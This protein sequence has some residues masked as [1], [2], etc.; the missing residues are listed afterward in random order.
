MATEKIEIALKKQL[1]ERID[2][3]AKMSGKSRN[4]FINDF[5]ESYLDKL[6]EDLALEK[7]AIK[8]YMAGK[9]EEKQLSL[10]VGKE[11]TE[12]AKISK[13]IG[14]KGEDLLKAFK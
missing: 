9:M 2:V 6:V 1:I 7:D 14:A 5:L 4:A 12:A 8:Q 13:R 3:L 10:I 11:K